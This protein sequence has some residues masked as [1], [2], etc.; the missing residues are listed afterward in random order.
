M[1]QVKAVQDED[2]H[3][4]VIPNNKFKEFIQERYNEEMIYEGEFDRKW[5]K[6]RTGGD[7]NIVQL[8]AEI[9]E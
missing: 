5:G 8:W 2:G 4:Y 1:I 7:L 3:W 6:Y 9:E